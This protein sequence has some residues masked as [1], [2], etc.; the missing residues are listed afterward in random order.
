MMMEPISEIDE[1]TLDDLSTP[2]SIDREQGDI[3]KVKKVCKCRQLDIKF[4]VVKINGGNYLH[5]FIFILLSFPSK[6]HPLICFSIV[7][8]KIAS[9]VRCKESVRA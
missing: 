4:S 9:F 3:I 7:G 6:L 5:A 1:T 8:I 2:T